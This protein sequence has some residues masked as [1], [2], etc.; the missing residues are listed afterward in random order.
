MWNGILR[1]R[2][3]GTDRE[4]RE[5]EYYIQRA[6]LLQEGILPCETPTY[7]YIHFYGHFSE[8]GIGLPLR[9]TFRESVLR[10]LCEQMEKMSPNKNTDPFALHAQ[11]YRIFSALSADTAPCEEPNDL[12]HRLKTYLDIKYT[13]PAP[14]FELSHRFGYTTDHLIRVFRTRYG[15]T[16]HR[17]LNAKRM[18]HAR[19]LL[20]TT[21]HSV[22]QIAAAVGYTDFS[23]FYR[24]FRKA[25]GNP[26]GAFRK[27]KQ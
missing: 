1:F 24:A 2:E 17:Y 6:G 11:M 16:P 26:P 12:A 3:D 23:A 15:I 7:F 4:L 14:L 18:D 27:R 19:W 10:P 25:H 5:G 20:E 9:G 22:E 13:E 8:T 21:E